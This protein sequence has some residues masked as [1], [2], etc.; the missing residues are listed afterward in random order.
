MLVE[1]SSTTLFFWTRE[2]SPCGDWGFQ[3]RDLQ[4]LTG[5]MLQTSPLQPSNEIFYRSSQPLHRYRFIALALNGFRPNGTGR[6]L[7]RATGKI[8]DGTGPSFLPA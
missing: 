5:S 8:S 6:P 4:A 1:Y 3:M 7:P 2:A